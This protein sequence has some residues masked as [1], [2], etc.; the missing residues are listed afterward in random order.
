MRDFVF[1]DAFFYIS[2]A[3]LQCFA[4]LVTVIQTHY[5][6]RTRVMGHHTGL[7]VCVCVFF[8]GQYFQV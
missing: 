8:I 5:K 2:P 6:Y 4:Y 1:S 7:C 3:A